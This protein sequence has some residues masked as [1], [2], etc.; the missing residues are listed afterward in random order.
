[1]RSL[2]FVPGDSERKL[3][4]SLE[5]GADAL[6]LD[7]EDS[8]A[9]E[10]KPKARVMTRDFLKAAGARPKRPRLYVRTNAL[11]TGLVDDDLEAV[12][13]AKPDGIML[14]KCESAADVILL[15]AKLSVAEALAGVEDSATRILAIVTETAA[16][17]F[18]LGGYS[19]ASPRLEGLTWGAEDLSADVGSIAIRHAD[20]TFTDPYRLAR[21]LCL[22]AASAARVLPIDS[23]FANFQ[24]LTGL[25]ADAEA[26]A[27]DGFVAKMAI[28][29]AQVPVIN[30]IFTPSNAA[31]DWARAVVAAFA[32][33]PGAGVVAYEG[34]MLDKPHLD[35]AERLLARARSAGLL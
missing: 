19:G 6:I 30:E 9:L 12:V 34:E 26:G 15:D 13:A 23:V 31:L 4:K 21:A 8:V 32:K 17:L 28:H 11:P 2:L 5:S 35:R 1:M 18:G 3:A 7:L 25:R 20:G 22:F 14:P 10:A 27:R 29:P 33:N 16:S 24:D